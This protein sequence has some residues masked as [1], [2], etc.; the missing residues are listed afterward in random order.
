MSN[1]ITPFGLFLVAA[2]CAA[3]LAVSLPFAMWCY[4]RAKEIDP[5][6]RRK[7]VLESVL[8]KLT[9][10]IELARE[11]LDR[12]ADEKVKARE[13]VVQGDQARQWLEEHRQEIADLQIQTVRMKEEY[14]VAKT[15]L[16]DIRQKV[17][18]RQTEL[19]ELNTKMLDTVE[20]LSNAEKVHQENVAK[21]EQLRD[22]LKNEVSSLGADK[23]SLLADKERLTNQVLQLRK[24]VE[25][26]EQ[27]RNE[28]QKLVAEYEARRELNRELKDENQQL[29]ARNSS[30]RQ[31]YA[32]AEKTI[33]RANTLKN[34]EANM[35]N[36]L[37]R[38]VATIVR[39]PPKAKVVEDEAAALKKFKSSLDSS[40]YAFSERTIKA[41]HTGLLCGGVSPLVVL[42]GVSG[43]GKSL[44]PEL[45]AKAF[46]MNF[47]PV[48][49]QPRWD[50]PQDVFG[51]YNHMEARFKA[52]E[53]SRL[54][55]QFDRFNNK[56]AAKKY[57][58]SNWGQFPMSLVLLDEMN[59]ARVEYY[60]S[61]LLSKLG[62]RNRVGNP[63]DAGSRVAAG[64][65]LEY[66]ASSISDAAAVQEMGR[67]LFVDHNILFVGTM[68][69]DE[70]TQTLSSKVIDRS[71][72]LRFGTPE[73]LKA[74]PDEQKFLDSCGGF[75]S[76]GT[77][78]SWAQ[79]YGKPLASV[80]D[81]VKELKEILKRVD[82]GFGHRTESAIKQYVSFYPGNKEDAL[83]DQ[84]EMKILP[85]LNGVETDIVRDSVKGGLVD[86][87]KSIHDSDVTNALEATLSGDSTFFAWKG[88]RR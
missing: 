1:L 36:D 31:E 81:V 38:P 53:L 24:D 79:E 9:K 20:R 21:L 70:S 32:D 60:F 17:S 3:L 10:D 29:V 69:E 41:F 18:S 76:Y 68:N 80:N 19:A 55:W 75:V 62:I 27:R 56:M 59:L 67:R 74:K 66:G 43:T 58:E 16:E 57:P 65:E 11:E 2:V 33:A 45:Y 37:D 63:S 64:V 4:L 46:G 49:V 35:W 22:E 40:G 13:L 12:L 71:N 34:E 6:L 72:V 61:E 54:I 23:A 82:C 88:V 28:L 47:L 85:K 48:A 86:V 51:F 15:Q 52:T 50:G 8:E 77:W 5:L 25:N 44:L 87:L 83:A 26:L 78:R 39:C 14:E 30:L 7:S 42:S 73:S 84:I